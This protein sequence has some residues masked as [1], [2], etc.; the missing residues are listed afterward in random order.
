MMIDNRPTLEEQLRIN[1]MSDEECI[2]ALCGKPLSWR[3]FQVNLHAHCHFLW[4][5]INWNWF[6]F[7][8]GKEH[9]PIPCAETKARNT[10]Q[11]SLERKA[12]KLLSLG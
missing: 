3:R 2:E 8:C 10:K 11:K 9:F 7:D 4:S 1:A 6:C 5:I 12:R